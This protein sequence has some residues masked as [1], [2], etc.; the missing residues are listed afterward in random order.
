MRVEDPIW[1][2]MPIGQPCLAGARRTFQD[3]KTSQP[4]GR[5]HLGL[6]CRREDCATDL[7]PA[8]LPSGFGVS[9]QRGPVLFKEEVEEIARQLCRALVVHGGRGVDDMFRKLERPR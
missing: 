7:L 2:A 5:E 8:L 1:F 4:E 6:I 9:G 3:Q